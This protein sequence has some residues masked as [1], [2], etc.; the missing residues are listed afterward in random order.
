MVMNDTC[1]GLEV[2]IQYMRKADTMSLIKQ[3]KLRARIVLLGSRKNLAQPVFEVERQR[4]F[5]SFLDDSI[6]HRIVRVAPT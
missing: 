5:D 6:S 1:V 3:R 2:M 4:R